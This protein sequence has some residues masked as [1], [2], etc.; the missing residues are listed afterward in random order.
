[1]K[2]I[3]SLLFFMAI[4]GNLIVTSQEN[5]TESLNFEANFLGDVVRNFDGGIKTGQTG[6]GLIHLSLAFNPEKG[7][8]WKGGEFFIHAHKLIGKSPSG[9]LIGDIQVASNIDGLT[10][11]FIYEFWYKQD[12]G[13]LSIL[14]GLHNL[15]EIFHVNEY[16]G[17]YLNS[18]FGISP[19][20]SLNDAISI[21][22]A[23]TLGGF[24]RWENKTLS[25]M[26]GMY[27]YNH[28]FPSEERFLLR[29]HNFSGGFY[30]LVESQYRFYKND[31][32]LVELKLG[33]R[34][35]QCADNHAHNT[36]TCNKRQDLSI[37]FL[38]DYSLFKTTTG[39]SG[40]LFLQTGYC[41]NKNCMSPFYFSIG[42]T[43]V[44]LFLPKM[45]DQLGIAYASASINQYN[46][47][48][49]RFNQ[50]RNESVLELTYK[51][52]VHQRIVIQPDLQYII[53]PAGADIAKNAFVGMLRT[54]ISF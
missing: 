48:S 25:F 26:G 21:F 53:N 12:F 14:G 13:N 32:K 20:L 2:R 15:N 50:F 42:G 28:S 45:E 4:S 23:T 18:S 40:G 41:P 3:Y 30:S 37:Y 8:W 54:E 27:N 11:R 43:L 22:P 5:K 49:N 34:L 47:A 16:A 46:L 51:L 36:E 24:I 6:L 10:N 39:K 38:T 52:Q 33:A 29:N 31:N 1:M 17:V 7:N 19:S 9:E 44:G 35:R